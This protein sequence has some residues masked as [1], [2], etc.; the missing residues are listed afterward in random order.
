LH[1]IFT[2]TQFRYFLSVLAK[3]DHELHKKICS[4]LDA[5]NKIFQNSHV[6]FKILD[7]FML[8]A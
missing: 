5:P 8:F 1:F 6:F 4:L 2:E 3:F 7:F